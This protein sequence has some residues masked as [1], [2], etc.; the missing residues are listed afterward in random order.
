MC[1][2]C[3]VLDSWSVNEITPSEDM[4]A[5]LFL[6]FE[7]KRLNVHCKTGK[8]VRSCQWNTFA[9]RMFYVEHRRRLYSVWNRHRSRDRVIKK[10]VRLFVVPSLFFF[11]FVSAEKNNCRFLFFQLVLSSFFF[12]LHVIAGWRGN[13]FG[14]TTLR[15]NNKPRDKRISRLEKIFTRTGWSDEKK[16]DE[17]K[18]TVEVNVKKFVTSW[19]HN[20]ICQLWKMSTILFVKKIVSVLSSTWFA[21]VR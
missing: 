11:T 14:L 10:F 3:F 8:N 15:T 20:K 12:R 18:D 4:H 2:C 7:W 17:T 16:T 13:S 1:F 9:G 21:G 5:L 6:L 19:Q